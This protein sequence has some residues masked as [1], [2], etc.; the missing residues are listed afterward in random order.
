VPFIQC[1]LR[2]RAKNDGC[3]VISG[4]F[5]ERRHAWTQI[6]QR[7]SLRLIQHDHAARQIMQ[8]AAAGGPRGEQTLEKLHVRRDDDRRGPVLHRQSQLAFA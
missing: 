2:C 1:W 3:L 4:K 6:G 8:F 5:V 7:D